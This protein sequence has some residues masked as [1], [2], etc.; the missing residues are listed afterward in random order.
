MRLARRLCHRVGCFT[1]CLVVARGLYRV[2]GRT[3]VVTL[4]TTASASTARALGLFT[5]LIAAS[6]LC[7]AIGSLLLGV[8]YFVTLRLTVSAISTV[9]TVV[10]AA[11][12]ALTVVVAVF[13]IVTLSVTRAVAGSSAVLLA[14]TA[15]ITLTLF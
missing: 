4:A 14:L 13:A 15:A 11:A 1:V 3:V 2:I 8:G 12:V 5:V 6:V 10:S 9:V 7:A